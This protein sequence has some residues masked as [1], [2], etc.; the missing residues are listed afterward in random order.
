M[1][2]LSIIVPVYNVEIYLKECLDSLSNQTFKDIEIICIND[3]SS[4]NSLDI[5]N[6][7]REEDNRIRVINQEN[8]GT[9]ASRN[10][11]LDIAKGKY[12]YFLDSDDFIDL[13]AL[14]DLYEIA[15][16]TYCDLIIFKTRNFYDKSKEYFDL[17]YHMM[18]FLNPLEN[19]SFHYSVLEKNLSHI[20]VTVYTKFFK[21][22][23]LSNIRFKEDKIF[24]DNLFTF[25]CIFN[26]KKIYLLLRI[27]STG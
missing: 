16:K 25:E 23:L 19:T 15:E 14:K 12:V 10:Q 21:R 13:N 2:Y 1:K 11:G 17:E 3:G 5:L 7:C 18:S 24:E 20:D 8:K 6:E 4:D 9:G 22:S 27:M 26:T